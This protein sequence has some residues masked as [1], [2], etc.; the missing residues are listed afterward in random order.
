METI[1]NVASAASK[2]IFGEQRAT[3]NETGGQEPISGAQ[4]QGTPNE[5]FDKGNAENPITG[6]T[7]QPTQTPVTANTSKHT[8]TPISDDTS[9]HPT[10]S[11]T[12]IMSETVIPPLV[13]ADRDPSSTSTGSYSS[14]HYAS[15]TAGAGE[16]TG[17]TGA[18]I[19]EGSGVTTARS[20]A[21]IYTAGSDSDGLQDRSEP[22]NSG[23][24]QDRSEPPK[25][26]YLD[27]KTSDPH[28]TTD[29]TGVVSDRTLDPPKAHD[30]LPTERALNPGVAP[31]SG[32]SPHVKHQGADAPNDA[33]TGDQR[34]AVKS[35]KDEAE[36]ILK[37]RDPNDHSGEPMKMHD[38]PEKPPTTQEE[39]RTSKAGNPGGQEHGKYPKGTGEE[40]VKTSGMA[41]D[42]GDFD[43]TKPG[44]GREADRLMEEKGVKKSTS[45]STEAVSDEQ[46]ASTAHSGTHK[47]K[48]SLGD[49]LKNKLHIGHKNK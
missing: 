16:S 30:V 8:E 49:K 29:K 22:S 33:P 41:V 3:Q 40:W 13:P 14:P 27:Y 17:R 39:R 46:P 35:Q 31:D 20:G 7:T 6:D 34:S 36:E 38:G 23:S 26:T 21:G 25:P 4:G 24:L 15:N 9:K 45:G 44:A 43:A 28:K 47:E 42:G 11:S 12:S 37:T 2:A 5:P 32:A 18:G 19:H 10:E 48:E 1:S